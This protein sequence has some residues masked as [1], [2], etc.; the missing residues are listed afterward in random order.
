MKKQGCSQGKYNI[1]G[2]CL[3]IPQI[4]DTYGRYY[5]KKDADYIL[6]SL[7]KNGIHASLTGSLTKKEISLND[8]DIR[9]TC[10]QLTE[11]D[12][13]KTI[14]HKL[15]RCI[16]KIHELPGFTPKPSSF[17]SPHI[18]YDENG[19]PLALV[20]LKNKGRK[21]LICDIFLTLEENNE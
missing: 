13:E 21:T 5:T 1:D 6:T 20:M 18:T 14:T 10:G 19:L 16:K 4:R 17:L 11:K 3:S 12:T 2:Q 15:E 8:I 7:H 9:V